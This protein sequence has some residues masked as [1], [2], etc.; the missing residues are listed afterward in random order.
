MKPK[1]EKEIAREQF[2]DFLT[3]LKLKKTPE[4]Y[5]ILDK[6]YSKKRP[7]EIETLLVDMTREKY[8]VSRATVYNTIK[9]LLD[10]GLLLRHQFGETIKYERILGTTHSHY[11]ICTDCGKVSTFFD[12]GMDK[13]VEKRSIPQF[14]ASHYTISVYGKCAKCNR[15]KTGK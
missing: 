14:H 3:K 13:F 8:N 9:I 4:L 7:F 10:C 1:S 12:E 2:P 5:V 11:L 6:V 15:K